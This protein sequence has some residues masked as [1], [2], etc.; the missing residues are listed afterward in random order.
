M[1][2]TQLKKRQGSD[3]KERSGSLV[4]KTKSPELTQQEKLELVNKVF[5][6]LKARRKNPI[7]RLLRFSASVL[8]LSFCAACAT[9]DTPQQTTAVTPS[10]E[11]PAQ[12]NL[13]SMSIRN[14]M[15]KPDEPAAFELEMPESDIA[16]ASVYRYSKEP[17][18]LTIAQDAVDF[19][20]ESGILVMLKKNRLETNY[21]PCIAIDYNGNF[22]AVQ[23]SG[24]L[25]LLSGEKE[26]AIADLKEC[27][28]VREFKGDDKGYFL[29][30]LALLEFSPKHYSLSDRLRQNIYNEGDFIGTVVY[31]AIGTTHMVF[32]T[33]TGKVALMNMRDGRFNA[34]S[35][36]NYQIKDIKYIGND[37]FIY[38]KDNKLLMLQPDLG[39]GTI[40]T[41]GQMQGKDGCFF[42]KR[43]GKM[44]C[45]GYIT[46]IDSAQESPTD[47]DSGLFSE[48]ML[49][50]K[51][52]GVLSFVDSTPVYRQSILLGSPAQNQVCVKDGR[53]YFLDLDRKIKYFTA[54]GTES[55]PASR[56]ES[57]DYVF[58]MKEGAV[59]SA[60]GKVIYQFAKPVNR[61]VKAVMLKRII[62]QDIYYYF[63][64]Q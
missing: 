1:C 54:E 36:D 23:L 5:P 39:D 27:G 61:S 55:V 22:N 6:S 40:K 32:A 12:Q 8:L 7:F 10:A 59:K 64:M 20:Y 14:G 4:L 44:F 17:T 11:T 18:V 25:V 19:D 63:E 56:P 47:A 31:G 15:T 35:P 2:R 43:S 41:I 42:L 16:L 53:G 38:T 24:Q 57:C 29:N 26:A 34:L 37:I 3:L 50:L 52:E 49:F 51:K 30:N 46:G 33:D 21:A 62:G 48:N 45:S 58:T 13:I 9:V 28:I 60:D